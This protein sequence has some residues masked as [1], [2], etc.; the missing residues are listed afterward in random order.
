MVENTSRTKLSNR[1]KV[2]LVV[3]L[4][5]VAAFVFGAPVVSET[6]PGGVAIQ[7]NAGSAYIHYQASLSCKLIGFG[8]MYWQGGLY[9][10]CMPL[11]A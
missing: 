9:F 1:Q 2:A 3:G 10:G 11:V 7:G 5:L 4:V 8:D 6:S